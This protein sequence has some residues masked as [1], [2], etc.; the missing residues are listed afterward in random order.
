METNNAR[1]LGREHKGVFRAF[2]DDFRQGASALFAHKPMASELSKQKSAQNPRSIA[3]PREPCR[4]DPPHQT[5]RIPS[6]LL[7]EAEYIRTFGY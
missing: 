5:G 7:K 4:P 2:D 6:Y 1:G 3:V